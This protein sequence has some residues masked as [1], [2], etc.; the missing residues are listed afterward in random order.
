MHFSRGKM[1]SGTIS[2]PSSLMKNIESSRAGKA[3]RALASLGLGLAALGDAAASTRRRQ[4]PA[5]RTCV[6]TD[7]RP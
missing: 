4:T 5:Q 6:P 7:Q 3:L 1:T 2:I